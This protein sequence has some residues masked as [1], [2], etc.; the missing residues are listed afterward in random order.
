MCHTRTTIFTC[1]HGA[2]TFHPCAERDDKEPCFMGIMQFE[3]R[4]ASICAACAE[5]AKGAVRTCPSPTPLY[6]ADN[7]ET[8]A[9]G[10][11]AKA[12][13]GARGGWWG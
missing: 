8:E 3:R 11:V 1:A 4:D 6:T 5:K 10:V 9:K 7:L 12:N 13:C 2:T